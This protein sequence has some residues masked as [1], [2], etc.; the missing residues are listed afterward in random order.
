MSQ[1][2]NKNNGFVKTNQNN[3]DKAQS[4]EFGYWK[5]L[6]DISSE[7]DYNQYLKQSD[8][9]EEGN[10]SRRNFLSL[11]AASVA[12]ASLEGCKKPVQKIIPYV[13]AHP[14]T[15]SGI[16][17]KY[18]T[19]MPFKNN[20]AGLVIEN[21]DERPIKVFGNDNHPTSLGKSN[22]F[23][24]ASILD[25]YDPDRARGIKLDGKKV[26]WSEYVKYAESIYNSKGEGLAVLLQESSSPTMH[27]LRKDFKKTYPNADWVVYEPINNENL[28]SGIEKALGKR[29]QPYNRLEKAKTILSISSDFLGSDD[30]NV[31]N[32]RKFAE[33]RRV[34]NKNST[35][36]RLYVVESSMT[37]TGASADHR[38]NIP[39]SELDIVLKELCSEL[40]KLGMNISAGSLKTSNN[41]WIKTVAE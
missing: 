10:L 8:H 2:K 26:D 18:T 25:M 40:K 27:A 19:T 9:Q 23:N 33:N 34:E 11:V 21:H 32:T 1:I 14:G 28:Y 13:E 24:Q 7:K 31:Y 29:L 16:R 39:T 20:V 12:L 30:N 22:V 35:M 3:N 5:S 17:K 37:S 4:R 6:K 38:L 41:L 15:I 36:N